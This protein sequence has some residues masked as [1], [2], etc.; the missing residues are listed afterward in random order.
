MVSTHPVLALCLLPARLPSKPYWWWRAASGSPLAA[1]GGNCIKIGIPG[2][3]I[4][5]DYYMTSRRPFLLLRISFRGRPIFLQ[6]VP[7]SPWRPS[8]GWSRCR[9][10]S[11]ASC[12][13]GSCPRRR[14]PAQPTQDSALSTAAGSEN[15]RHVSFWWFWLF[16]VPLIVLGF[17]C[18]FLFA[19]I[20]CF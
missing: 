15:A 6:F 8:R 12:W 9:T 5:R 4:F 14:R 2:K 16:L 20:I 3:L 10:A 7:G 17:F 18:D 19:Y 11:R 13:E 1:S